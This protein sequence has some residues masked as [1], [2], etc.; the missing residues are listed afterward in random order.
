MYCGTVV[1]FTLIS[2][3]DIL[4]PS[5]NSLMADLDSAAAPR[6]ARFCGKITCALGS[7]SN[8]LSDS[9]PALKSD[10]AFSIAVLF[11]ERK[12]CKGLP[13]P[14]EPFKRYRVSAKRQLNKRGGF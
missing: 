1:I 5:S 12:Q 2:W 9:I 13:G 8:S 6:D 4:G 14:R 7:S 3:K 10:I 11:V